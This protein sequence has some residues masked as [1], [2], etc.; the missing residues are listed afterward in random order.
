MRLHNYNPSPSICSDQ[1]ELFNELLSVSDF[2]V[3]PSEQI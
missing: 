2:S 3:L 1:V